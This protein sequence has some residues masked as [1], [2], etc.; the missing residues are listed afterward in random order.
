MTSLDRRQ[1]LAEV[2]A[3]VAAAGLPPAPPASAAH[4]AA[5]DQVPPSGAGLGAPAFVPL[6][7]GA[8][9]PTG[10]LLRQR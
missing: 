2:A 5:S 1:F 4:A 9:R 7:L 10:W 6:P 8:V 3:G